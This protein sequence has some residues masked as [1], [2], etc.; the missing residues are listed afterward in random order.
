M[1]IVAFITYRG[2]R[3]VSISAI[4][5]SLTLTSGFAGVSKFLVRCRIQ[6]TLLTAC[7]MFVSCTFTHHESAW[8]GRTLHGLL[9]P[10]TSRSCLRAACRK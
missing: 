5:S 4:S 2:A 8:H 10:R 3:R 6:C 7:I 1:I 9:Y